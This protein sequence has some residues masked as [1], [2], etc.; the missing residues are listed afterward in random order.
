MC[1]LWKT[2]RTP[3]YSPEKGRFEPIKAALAWIFEPVFGCRHSHVTPP[4]NGHQTCRDC[5]ARRTYSFNWGFDY[6][7]A[8]VYIG[9]WRK[10]V[11]TQ[12][13]HRVIAKTLI[14]NALAPISS[15]PRYPA[16]V[17]GRIHDTTN[18]IMDRRIAAA[19]RAVR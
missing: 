3:A 16:T 2:L 9:E 13:A 11:P 8:G 12:N 4:F 7:A 5:G 6:A 17:I 14:A 19:E 15:E 1:N 10:H 18:G